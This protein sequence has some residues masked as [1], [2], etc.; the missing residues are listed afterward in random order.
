LADLGVSSAQLLD[1]GLISD[2]QFTI[3]FPL[4]P[5]QLEFTAFQTVDALW[6]QPVRVRAAE[7]DLDRVSQTMVQNGLDVIRD[8][9]VAHASLLL[10][11]EQAMVAREAETP[12]C[13]TCSEAARRAR[14]Q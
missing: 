5:K 1:V 8:V 9:R 14:H 12:D 10:A 4:G 3:F 2:P 11:Q 7:L 13:G 6:L